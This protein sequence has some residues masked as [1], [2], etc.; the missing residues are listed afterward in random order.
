MTDRKLQHVLLARFNYRHEA[1]F[2]AGFLREAGIPYLLQIEDPTLGLSATDSSTLWVTA[3]DEKRARLVLDHEMVVDEE[4]NEAWADFAL[5]E[6][7]PTG[8]DDGESPSPSAG[9]PAP[10]AAAPVPR[11]RPV[12]S[13]S[14]APPGARRNIV[15]PRSDLTL[16]GRIVALTGS[17][18][19]A[20]TLVLEA[21]RQNP[22][23]WWGVVLVAALLALAGVFGRAPGPLR[24]ILQALSGDAP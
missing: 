14:W 18:G 22:F 13:D 24:G 15:K 9:T 6:G 16:R 3:V 19:I 21:V 1:E 8:P 17:V 10:S 20:S 23:V 5:E 12:E 7:E 2:A 11:R 4:G